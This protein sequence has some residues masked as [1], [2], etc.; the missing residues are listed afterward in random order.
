VGQVLEQVKCSNSDYLAFLDDNLTADREYALELFARLRK[1]NVKF[2]GQVST[3]FILDDDL[4]Q[5]AVAAGL[6]AIF[7]GS[8]PLKKRS[9]DA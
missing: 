5:M 3:K 6:K 4:F 1:M 9:L 8:R 7:V 2:I